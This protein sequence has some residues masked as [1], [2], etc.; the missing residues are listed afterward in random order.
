MADFLRLWFEQDGQMTSALANPSRPSES[1]RPIALYCWPLVRADRFDVEVLA[2]ELVIVLRVSNRRL[3]QLAP[4]ARDRAGGVSEDSSRL[5]DALSADVVANQSRLPSRGAD[6]FGL[7]ADFDVKDLSAAT[8][9]ARCGRGCRRAAAR[10][11][12]K[13]TRLNSSHPSI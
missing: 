9:A 5:L 1:A 3:E 6:I 12:R 10:G 7:G 2:D 4:I 11:D 8:A 13:R